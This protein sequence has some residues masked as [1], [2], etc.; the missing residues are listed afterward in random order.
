MAIEIR[1]AIFSQ[2]NSTVSTLFLAYAGS[3]PVNLDFQ[4]FKNELAGLPGKYAAEKGGAVFLAYSTAEEEMVGV[5]GVRK[6]TVEG[7]EVPTCELKRLYI[8]PASRG[9]GVAKLLMDA[10]LARAREL[11]YREMLLD[12]LRSMTP[13]R[14]LYAHYGFTETLAYYASVE[15]AMFYKL[16]L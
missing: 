8:A 1:P 14:K 3:L 9:K 2:D 4:N 11:G 15:G 13:A 12:T 5:V 6:F 16:L 10:V 7:S